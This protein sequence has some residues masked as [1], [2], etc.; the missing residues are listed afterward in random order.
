MYESQVFMF[1]SIFITLCQDWGIPLYVYTTTIKTPV[2]VFFSPGASSPRFPLLLLLHH[3]QLLQLQFHCVKNWRQ[4]RLQH[5]GLWQ[6]GDGPRNCP[7]RSPAGVGRG[8]CAPVPA[9]FPRRPVPDPRPFEFR[10]PC[11]G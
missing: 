3:H 9:A 8:R 7:L 1:M 2:Q 11:A 4:S 6:P 5:G 10:S